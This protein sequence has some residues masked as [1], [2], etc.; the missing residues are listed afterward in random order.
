MIVFV[1]KK[2]GKKG[3]QYFADLLK[4]VIPPHH[5]IDLMQ[6]PLGP[7]KG[8]PHLNQDSK[9]ICCGG[10]GTASWVISALQAQSMKN[11]IGIFPLGTGNDLSKVLGWPIKE[12]GYFEQPKPNRQ[13]Q[14]LQ[15]LSQSLSKFLEAKTVLLDSWLLQTDNQKPTPFF[16]YFSIGF[17]SRIAWEFH[18]MRE[19]KGDLFVAQK[20]N[21][22]AATL[23]V[24]KQRD[25][26]E[27][28]SLQV[29][30]KEVPLSK[31]IRS[32]LFLNIPSYASG[33]NPWGGS[34]GS[35]ARQDY[36]DGVL[37]VIGLK[38]AKQMALIQAG[39]AKGERIAQGASATLKVFDDAE[40]IYA[41][42]DGEPWAL[43]LQCTLQLAHSGQS[44]MLSLT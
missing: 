19:E 5:I 21:Y 4:E 13:H 12:E 37:E 26:K 10:D 36:S 9:I 24:K 22:I 14:D 20:S 2:S 7:H 34:L 32:L 43:P 25:V 11:P 6:T 15:Y 30:G 8:F 29:D 27:Y 3:G 1:N 23:K 35:W 31:G 39:L 42:T 17:D 41:Q 28:A 18:K 38:G 33:S 16:N 44:P 40:T